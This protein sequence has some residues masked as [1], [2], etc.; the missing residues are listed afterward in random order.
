[1]EFVIVTGMSGA[2]KSRVI[3]A[4][5]DVGYYC[6]DNMPLDF[7]S[8]FAKIC[9][10]AQGK[11]SRVAIVTDIRSGAAFDELTQEISELKKSGLNC[12]I[13]FLD[14]SESAIIRRY[15]ET[16]RRHPLIE[17][18]PKSPIDE[19][20]EYE[21]QALM[22]L[23]DAADDIIDTSTLTA[24][25]LKDRVIK[26]FA[27]GQKSIIVSVMSFGFKYGV[28]PEADMVFDARCLPNPYYEL[29]LRDYS[30]LDF[31]VREFVFKSDCA[32]EYMEKIC[33]M[34]GFLMPL[35]MEEGKS[36]L[37]TA[38]GCTGGRHR[39][40]AMAEKL[41]AYLNEIGYECE[42]YH[43]DILKSKPKNI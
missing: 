37:M 21:R 35:F 5:E 22:P 39:S 12:R 13:I 9:K 6:V 7:I 16:R 36:S 11:M 25:Q 23:M 27:Q 32:N 8:K 24:S 17:I 41:A 10:S 40:V 43:R 2:G 15:K 29:E 20:I 34:T 33:D 42:I 38:I 31:P 28:P 30:G 4:M 19:I 3:E 14:A 26:M 1:M 18:L